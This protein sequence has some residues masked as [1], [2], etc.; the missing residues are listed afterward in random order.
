MYRVDVSPS[1]L[2]NISHLI[3]EQLYSLALSGVTISSSDVKAFVQSLTST[4]LDTLSLSHCGIS[5]SE[6]ICLV[7][8]IGRSSLKYF[9]IGSLEM[10]DEVVKELSNVLKK[11]K[12]LEKVE[13]SVPN[14]SSKVS[15]PL[16]EA[17]NKSS[18]KK[19]KIGN[20]ATIE[21]VDGWF[22]PKDKVDIY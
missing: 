11:S 1:C 6:S 18:L 2:T 20:L 21:D 5:N 7:K 16:I 15:R 13:V 19:L 9:S 4:Q 17:M 14:M 3:S 10:E 22:Y 12:S 8:G